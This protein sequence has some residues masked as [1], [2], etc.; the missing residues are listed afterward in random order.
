MPGLAKKADKHFTY[1]DY[2]AWP[3]DERWEII[4]G[5][6]YAMSSP[7]VLH[8]DVLLNLAVTLKPF[9]NG[10]PCRFFI[11]PL[12][13]MLS[14]DTVVQ[15]DMLVVCDPKKIT[16]TCVRGAPDLVVEILSPS[17]CSYDRLLKF[18]RYASAGVKEYWIVTPELASIEIFTLDNG[19]FRLHDG[20]LQQ[21]RLTSAV[22]PEV[23]FEMS[24][25]FTEPPKKG[26]L[27][28]KESFEMPECVRKELGL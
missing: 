6:A 19:A 4:D 11:A 17:S 18:K 15:P 13:V 8:Q 5:A 10:K 23:S 26:I 14:E 9:F 1:D 27:V 21:E 7:A 12:D 2:L 20:F 3:N 25:V 28:A 22:F 24:A 16:R